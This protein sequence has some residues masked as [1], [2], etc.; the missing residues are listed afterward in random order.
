MGDGEKEGAVG[1]MGGK[2][3]RCSLLCRN[4]VFREKIVN[5]T[6]AWF[7]PRRSQLHGRRPN[8]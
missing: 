5:E 2:A 8:S 7:V 3:S 1:G 6:M 4:N